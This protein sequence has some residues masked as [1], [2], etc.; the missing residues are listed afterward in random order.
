MALKLREIELP[1]E[2]E[3]Q[4]RAAVSSG[5]FGS[6][7]E[8]VAEALGEWAVARTLDH[9]DEEA[10]RALRERLDRAEAEAERDGFLPG[11]PDFARLLA[12]ARREHRG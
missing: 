4:M 3:A 1:A 11:L 5:D 7:E 8:V 9:M 2:T 10:L 12:A 6:I